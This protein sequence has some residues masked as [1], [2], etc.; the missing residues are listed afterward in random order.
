VPNIF[1]NAAKS[2]PRDPPEHQIDRTPLDVNDIGGRKSHLPPV[3]VSA[4]LPV[5]HVP[6]HSAMPG[7]N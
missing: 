7:E 1:Q 3:H 6:N 5:S 2:I 4:N